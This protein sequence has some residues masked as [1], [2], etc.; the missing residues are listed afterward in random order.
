[1]STTERIQNQE[2]QFAALAQQLVDRLGPRL[3]ANPAMAEQIVNELE[4]RFEAAMLENARIPRPADGGLAQLIGVGDEAAR[5]LEETRLPYQVRPYDETVNTPRILSTGDLYYIYQHEMVGV[6]AAVLK[7]QEL[8]KAG[9][10]RLSDGD[11]AY[12]LYQYDRREVLRHTT[13]DRMQAYRRV[14]GYTQTPPPT[15]AQPN[16]KFHGLFSNFMVQVS[17]FFRDKRVSEVVRSNANDPSFANI[18]Q[19][20]RAGL[21]LRNNLK[22]ASYGHVNV[23]RV[24]LLQLLDEAFYILGAEDIRDLFGADN[25]WD[26][27]EEVQRRYLGRIYIPSSER[28]RMAISGRAVIHW[29]GQNHILNN[30]RAEF[31]ALLTLIADDADE[32]LMSAQSLQAEQPRVIPGVGYRVPPTARAREA[33]IAALGELG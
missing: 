33:E 27:I 15:G 7:L 20:R 8:F 17:K 18:A 32:W 10:V 4:T 19:V 22:N 5:G 9:T 3:I 21:A 11:G 30:S 2:Q 16:R 28:S 14:F 29:L 1:M 31:E 24:E 23:L 25:A 13:R 26:V 12:H 6:F